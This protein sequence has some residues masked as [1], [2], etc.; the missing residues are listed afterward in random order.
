MKEESGKKGM[1]EGMYDISGKERRRKGGK[2]GL[3]A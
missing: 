1:K 2:D 3:R